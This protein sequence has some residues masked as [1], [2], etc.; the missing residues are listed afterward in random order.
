MRIENFV[1]VNKLWLGLL[2]AALLSSC[3]FHLRGAYQLPAVMKMTY[4]DAAN[5]NSDLIR[6]LKRSLKASEITLLE[7]SSAASAVLKVGSA[8]K[9]KR[10]VSVDSQGRAREYTLS[11]SLSFS[12]KASDGEFEMPEQTISI[13]RDFL[14]DTEDVLGKS[15]EEAQLYVEMEQDI[16]RLILLRLQSH[17]QQ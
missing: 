11:Y 17:A 15:K 3:G 12:L 16:V 10:T 14:F 6:S 7:N 4:V 13:N 2:V 1:F 9:S 8:Q 5:E